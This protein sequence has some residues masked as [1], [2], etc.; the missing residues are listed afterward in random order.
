VTHGEDLRRDQLVARMVAERDAELRGTGP[1]EVVAWPD[2]EERRAKDVEFV[3]RDDAGLVAVEHTIIESYPQQIAETRVLH[4]MFP[5]GGPELPEVVE[6]G[7]YRLLVR[8]EDLI[9]IAR[10]DRR[11][12][13]PQVQDWVRSNLPN[14]PWPHAAAKPTFGRGSIESPSL[15]LSLERWIADVSIIGPLARVVL[16]GF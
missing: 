8:S 2:A 7:H 9:W 10:T 3:G 14:V 5:L 12:V 15:E 4:E 6:A 16:M 13:G 11:R 1:V